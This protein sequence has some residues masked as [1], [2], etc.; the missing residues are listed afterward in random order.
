M[1][2]HLQLKSHHSRAPWTAGPHACDWGTDGPALS[3][4]RRFAVQAGLPCHTQHKVRGSMCHVDTAGLGGPSAEF[5][6]VSMLYR[7]PIQLQ[8]PPFIDCPARGTPVVCWCHYLLT[9]ETQTFNSGKS[10]PP[11]IHWRDCKPFSQ[12]FCLPSGWVETARWMHINYAIV[13]LLPTKCLR[14]DFQ[15][16][17]PGAAL[18]W[19]GKNWGTVSGLLLC[20]KFGP[21]ESGT[22]NSF[23]IVYFCNSLYCLVSFT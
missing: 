2:G 13:T 14:T 21:V 8:E 9:S 7:T 6:A 3:W 23:S 16:V 12:I 19:G 1:A 4:E 22:V 20:G 18:N 5:Q 11:D 15:I 17:F 10:P